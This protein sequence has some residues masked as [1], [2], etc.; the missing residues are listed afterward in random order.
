MEVAAR[1]GR[2]DE[3]CAL[4]IGRLRTESLLFYAA[5]EHL[6]GVNIEFTFAHMQELL[7]FVLEKGLV[8]FYDEGRFECCRVRKVLLL[9]KMLG[10]L[11]VWATMRRKVQSTWRNDIRCVQTKRLST[12]LCTS[13]I[14]SSLHA[15]ASSIDDYFPLPISVFMP[16]N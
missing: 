7:Y 2:P 6:Y 12:P 9:K 4:G 16:F 10:T 5:V 8:S 14:R 3:E 15:W 13:C 11:K 1:T